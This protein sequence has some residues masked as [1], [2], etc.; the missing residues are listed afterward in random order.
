MVFNAHAHWIE[1]TVPLVTAESPGTGTLEPDASDPVEAPADIGAD[2]PVTVTTEQSVEEA[3]ADPESDTDTDT[4]TEAV[5]DPAAIAAP[6]T[7]QMPPSEQDTHSLPEPDSNAVSYA[8]HAEPEYRSHTADAPSE[9]LSPGRESESRIAEVAPGEA[10]MEDT[11]ALLTDEAADDEKSS[12]DYVDFRPLHKNKRPVLFTALSSG[13]IFLLLLQIGYLY[14]NLLASQLP[15]SK[16]VLMSLCKVFGCTI[17]LPRA[18]DALKLSSSELITDPSQPALM[19]V[20][21]GLENLSDTAVA[22]PYISLAL[23]NDTSEI[24]VKR[25]FKPQDYSNQAAISPGIAPGDEISGKLTLK[26]DQISVSNYKIL[27][28]Y[29]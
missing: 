19:N 26:L 29:P 27:L 25:N 3:S 8:D 5:V 21:F 6:A 11:D 18:I 4:L 17:A 10:D 28:Y 9:Y 16:P 20:S 13:L 14:R 24:V 23:I 2:L 12:A 15:Q 22:Y 1:T 7:E